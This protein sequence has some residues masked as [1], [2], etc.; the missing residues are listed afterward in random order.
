MRYALLQLLMNGMSY[1][2]PI[3]QPLLHLSHRF[4]VDSNGKGRIDSYIY[5][6]GRYMHF[7]GRTWSDPS[8][9][10]YDRSEVLRV[11]PDAYIVTIRNGKLVKP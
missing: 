4:L 2:K 3:R 6:E 10:E 8:L 1:D 7:T 9:L 5:D 11:Y